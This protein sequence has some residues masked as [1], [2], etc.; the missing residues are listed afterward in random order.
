MCAERAVSAAVAGTAPAVGWSAGRGAPLQVAGVFGRSI[1]RVK[2]MGRKLGPQ[3][4]AVGGI[5]IG[6][7]GVISVK[8]WCGC[9]SLSA[10]G[11]CL[12]GATGAVGTAE[13]SPL[14][15]WG[16]VGWGVGAGRSGGR[17]LCRIDVHQ[18]ALAFRGHVLALDRVR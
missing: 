9:E 1:W 6:R 8:K 4:F 7:G 14:S 10:G 17:L 18:L 3:R 13:A 15:F 11:S 2:Q 5:C 16:G 12:P